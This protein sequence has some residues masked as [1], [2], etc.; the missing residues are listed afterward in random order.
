MLYKLNACLILFYFRDN[1]KLGDGNLNF[2]DRQS[3][4][5]CDFRD[6]PKLG[7]GNQHFEIFN[8]IRIDDNFRDNPKLGDGNLW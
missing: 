6:N 2:K 7:D 3:Y 8:V 1:P 4:H 5:V